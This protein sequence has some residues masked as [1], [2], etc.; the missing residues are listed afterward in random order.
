LLLCSV[1]LQEVEEKLAA[2]QSTLD[3]ESEQRSKVAQAL[4]LVQQARKAIT[5]ARS[6]NGT[7]DET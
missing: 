5:D 1:H 3:E 6:V 2:L 7:Q 4:E